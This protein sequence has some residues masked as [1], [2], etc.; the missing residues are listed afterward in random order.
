MT[1]TTNDPDTDERTGGVPKPCAKCGK[2]KGC[3]C[4]TVG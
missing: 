2:V 1:Q 4:P 3:T